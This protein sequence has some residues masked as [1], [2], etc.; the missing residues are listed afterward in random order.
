MCGELEERDEAEAALYARYLAHVKALLAAEAERGSE[1]TED[2]LNDYMD[3][4][5]AD[6]LRVSVRDAAASDPSM[7]YRTL[8]AQALA[9]ARLA[10][11]LAAH[12][13]LRDEPLRQT[14]EA[15]MHGYGELDAAEAIPEEDSDP[16]EKNGPRAEITVETPR[17]SRRKRRSH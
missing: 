9:F 1:S 14:I 12:L 3:R 8:G 11:F 13:A 15:L 5:F 16:Q 6:L 4:L 7:R 2:P 17:R 10:G